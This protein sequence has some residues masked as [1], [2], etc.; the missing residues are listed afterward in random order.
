MRIALSK[1]GTTL[2]S[3]QSGKEAYSAF[4]QNLKNLGNAEP[5]EVDFSNVVTFSPSWG[6]EFL[7]ALAD[8]YDDR[9][10]LIN[11]RGNPSVLLTLKILGEIKKYQWNVIK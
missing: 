1:F 10:T 4:A 9:L 8:N 6:D 3:R 11:V 7:G 5:V 2:V